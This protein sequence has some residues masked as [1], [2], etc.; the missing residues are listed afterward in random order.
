MRVIL[1]PVADRPECIPALEAAFDLAERLAANVVGC[2]LRPHRREPRTSHGSHLTVVLE[3]GA[4]PELPEETIRLN[5][6]NARRLFRRMA[7]Q[8]G[9]PLARKPRVADHALAYW[10][11]MVGSP[12][13]V[14]S[15]IGP[16]SDCIVVS[17][18][19]SRSSGPARA[20]LL[21]ALLRTGKPLLVLPQKRVAR[22]G[23]RVLIAWDQ[24]TQ[25]AGAVKAALPLLADAEQ[26]H[27]TC[28]GQETNPGPKTAQL[29][30]YLRHWGIESLIHREKGRAPESELLDVYRATRS[31]LLVMGAYS[32]S[33]LRERVLG[34][35]THEMLFGHNV[36]VF[37]LHS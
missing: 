30:G 15:I 12:Q 2:H 3:E 36:P 13:K 19:K 11:E 1:V 21:S 16:M 4:L 5:S 23:R 8:R 37:A 33:R 25:A 32:R 24:S 28:C 20:F 22:L 6:R 26:V 18:P 14:L 9:I 17:R 34:G 31:S 29:Q 35:M 7:Q 10:Q 27:I